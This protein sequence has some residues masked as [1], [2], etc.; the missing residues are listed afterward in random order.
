MNGKFRPR[1]GRN[2]TM[3]F[4]QAKSITSFTS[5]KNQKTVFYVKRMFYVFIYIYTHTYMYIMFYIFIYMFVYIY[6]SI[7]IYIY[8]TKWLTLFYIKVTFVHSSF[9]SKVTNKFFNWYYQDAVYLSVDIFS[10]LCDACCLGRM[11]CVIM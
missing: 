10:S 3:C 1:N 4:R 7:C 2:N 6:L 9:E 8:K 5:Y 11:H